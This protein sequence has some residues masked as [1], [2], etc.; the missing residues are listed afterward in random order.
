MLDSL[1][2][3]I[4]VRALGYHSDKG[5]PFTA[6][7]DKQFHWATPALAKPFDDNSFI[8]LRQR[9]LDEDR[10]RDECGF[11]V[12][13]GDERRENRVWRIGNHRLHLKKLAS[14]CL[15]VPDKRNLDPRVAARPLGNCHDID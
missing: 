7:W 13:L 14:E 8:L 12:K 15:S 1:L 11:G 3:Q 2:F 5:P 9:V 10:A 6:L 4:V